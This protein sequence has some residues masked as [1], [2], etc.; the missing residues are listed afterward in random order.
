MV[1]LLGWCCFVVL[2]CVFAGWVGFSLVCCLLV[3]YLV[4]G[5]ID[6]RDGWFVRLALLSGVTPLVLV[7]GGQLC[8]WLVWLVCGFGWVLAWCSL[9]LTV[10]FLV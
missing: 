10:G 2:L 3:C 5:L 9:V 4:S 6:L 7:T 1:R 8:C